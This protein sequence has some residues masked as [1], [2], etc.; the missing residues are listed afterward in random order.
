ML[1]PYLLQPQQR[2]KPNHTQMKLKTTLIAALSLAA[3]ATSQAFTIDFDSLRIISV[4]ETPQFV[5]FSPFTL[6]EAG[7]TTLTMDVAGYG[8]VTFTLVA[9]STDVQVGQ[10][11]AGELDSAPRNSLEFTDG[12]KVTVTFEGAAPLVAEDPEFSYTANNGGTPSDRITDTDLGGNVW[13]LEYTGA[14]DGAGLT[15]I[16]W[17][18]VPEPSSAALGA[19]GMSM[20]LLR[21]RKA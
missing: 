7:T 6:S 4:D 8:N 14:G 10:Q 5:G 3:M 11:F 19:L 20:I 13:Q 16:E 12:G 2:K 9:G 17:N 15:K 21:R 18:V 1:L